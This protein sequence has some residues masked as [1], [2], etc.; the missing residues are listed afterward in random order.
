MRATA[1]NVADVLGQRPNIGSLA[2]GN[3]QATAVT[4]EVEQLQL[5]NRYLTGFP[6]HF[7]ALSGQFVERLAI[8][9]ECRIHR[10]NLAYGAKETKQGRFQVR[11]R[12]R[13]RT[14]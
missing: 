10:W 5:V 8:A 7:D 11:L 3:A 14:L 4:G 13:Y 12:K 1:E 6:L 2:A 9:L